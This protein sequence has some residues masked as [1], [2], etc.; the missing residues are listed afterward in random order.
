MLFYPHFLT[1]FFKSRNMKFIGLPDVLLSV[2]A[3]ETLDMLL[4]L[5][6]LYFIIDLTFSEVFN[7][8]LMIIR[9]LGLMADYY[10]SVS[11]IF[12]RNGQSV[13]LMAQLL[14]IW[15]GWQSHWS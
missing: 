7:V 5:L 12:C 2:F 3:F 9:L 10:Y 6:L 1:E 4:S 14:G 11:L 8:T 15:L 13:S